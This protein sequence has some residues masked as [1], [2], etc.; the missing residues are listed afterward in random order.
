MGI[1]YTLVLFDSHDLKRR[2]YPRDP[3]FVSKSPIEFYETARFEL[4]KSYFLSTVIDSLPAFDSYHTGQHNMGSYSSGQ[5]PVRESLIYGYD[6]DKIV[7][8][9]PY[10][11]FHAWLWN[12]P[13]DDEYR[14][15]D[16][17]LPLLKAI[18]TFARETKVKAVGIFDDT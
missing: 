11:D 3:T 9:H 2:D 17:W 6:G 12:P 7:V 4:G 8:P 13:P 10:Y 18:D 5:V 1:C 16:I 15:L 14:Y